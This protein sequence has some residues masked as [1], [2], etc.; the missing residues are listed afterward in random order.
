[1]ESRYLLTF[2]SA[3]IA[4]EWWLLLQASFPECTRPGPQLFSFKDADLL[5][6]AWKHPSFAHLKSKW[7]YISFSDTKE[8]GLGGAAQGIIPVQDAQGNM[9]GGSAPASPD[10]NQVR[11]EAK[12][13]RNEMARLEEFFERMMEAVES[14]TEQ[15][16]ALAGKQQQ[17]SEGE[18][19]KSEAGGYFDMGELSSHLGHINDLLARNAEHAEGLATRQLENDQKLHSTLQELSSR[20]KKDYLG[21]SQLSTHLNRIQDTIEQTAK[22]RK[23]NA[24]EIAEQ[25]AQPANIDFSPLTDRLEKVQEAVEQ[26]SA[27]IRALLDEGTGAESKP[28]TPFWGKDTAVQ[29]SQQQVDLS[30]LTEHLQ[31]IHQAIEQQSSHMQ[32]LVGFA[33]G[34]EDDGSGPAAR[35]VSAGGASGSDNPAEKN[36]APLGE[37]LEQIYNA[38]EEGN[39]HAKAVPQFDLR[40]LVEAQE[41]TRKAVE[42]GGQS[43]DFT[44]LTQKFDSLIEHL[45]STQTEQHLQ[46]LIRKQNELA[47]VVDTNKPADLTPLAAKVD[48][49]NEHL[50]SL[51]E[52]SEFQSEQF[53]ELIDAQKASSEGAGSGAVDFA[54][55]TEHLQAI[56]AASEQ[57]AEQIR[58]LAEVQQTSAPPPAS[59]I[60]FTPVTERLSRI[61]ASL[62]KQAADH[63]DQSPGS[64]APKFLLS[65]LTSHLSKIQ[66]VT[67]ANA[68]NVKALREKQTASQDKM[69]IAVA[70][71][72]DQ[73][74]ALAQYHSQ[75]RD[76]S[77]S[78]RAHNEARMEAT[79][80]QVREL[81][82]G[83]REMVEVMRELAKSITAQNKASCD[84]VVIP[85]PR[86]MGRKVVGFVYDG[87]DG[88]A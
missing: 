43:A 33:S 82:A 16:A 12:A 57:N 47:A 52:W 83:Q 85:P 53:K 63:R 22:E 36:L 59:E 58:Y 21:M 26:N 80:G 27:L 5:T 76:Q 14:N 49:L 3:S 86:K 87:K 9:L 11:K 30:P 39:K 7:M 34:G 88:S 46:E 19:Q 15:V 10:L 29:Q 8:N 31:K 70:Q 28:G 6:K 4:N 48:G 20:E 50:E 67:E 84:H 54:P 69:H 60:D 18:G 78:Y 81:M 56:R 13:A 42:A 51:R 75:T 23:D 62:E 25:H 32:A 79:D 24:K 71:T 74:R 44:P 40:P 45:R 64:G 2:A 68:Q 61:H 77:S 1:M 38:I 72:A 66:A 55:L 17:R 35:P 73:V 41:A 37:H 65:A